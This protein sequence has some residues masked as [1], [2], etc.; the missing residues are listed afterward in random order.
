MG[1]LNKLKKIKKFYKNK[2]SM[3]TQ[4]QFIKRLYSLLEYGSSLYNA[5]EALKYEPAFI[6]IVEKIKISLEDGLSIDEAFFNAN[7][8]ENITSYLYFVRYNFDLKRCLKECMKLLE[9]QIYFRKEFIKIIR[10]PI[11]LFLIFFIL[12]FFVKQIILPSFQ[13]LYVDDNTT[14]NTFVT[15]I[16]YFITSIFLLSILF[17]LLYIAYKVKIKKLPMS[18]YLYIINKIP[19]YRTYKKYQTS[20]LFA[21]HFMNFLK[22]GLSIK[23]ILSYL[24]EQKK[25]KILS[26]YA[27]LL[28]VD[29][30]NGVNLSYVLSQPSLMLID[31]QLKHAFS[32]ENE[33]LISEELHGYIIYVMEKINDSLSSWL[34]I[35]Q[36]L[37]FSIIGCFIILI[38]LMIMYPMFSILNQL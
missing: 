27:N 1:I 10:Y 28:S 23:Q 29:L 4:L 18:T 24:S 25:F 21:H 2:I 7:F 15:L 32:K 5:L 16:D 26:Y 12:L 14:I 3:E 35:I 20:Y 13:Q 17:S 22:A 34:K 33:K 9:R 11:F 37:V 30:E 8:N 31:S 19:L 38:Y 6:P 36:P